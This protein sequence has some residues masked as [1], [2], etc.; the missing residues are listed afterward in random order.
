MRIRADTF[1]ESWQKIPL[2]HL[3]HGIY[4]WSHGAQVSHLERYVKVP[5]K[6]AIKLCP[7]LRAC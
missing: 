1:F 2:A 7:K 4:L 5:S 3:L 6:V